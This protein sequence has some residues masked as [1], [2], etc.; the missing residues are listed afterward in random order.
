MLLTN[1]TQCPSSTYDVTSQDL[2]I[3]L[4]IRAL[5]IAEKQRSM[6]EFQRH[7]GREHGIF[8]MRHRVVW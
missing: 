2:K 1:G 5:Q 8:L 7:S 6:W 4:A 3:I